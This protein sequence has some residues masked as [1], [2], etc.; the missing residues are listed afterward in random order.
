[1]CFPTHSFLYCLI[2]PV[3]FISLGICETNEK[4]KI[5]QKYN[6]TQHSNWQ[7]SHCSFFFTWLAFKP[8]MIQRQQQL[9]ILSSAASLNVLVNLFSICGLTLF[10]WWMQTKAPWNWK[11]I[12][13]INCDI[14]NSVVGDGTIQ[15]H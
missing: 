11:C 10:G 8:E 15:F 5:I 6:N 14:Y 12:L 2:K 7:F 3:S 9:R 4:E 13:A 1:M